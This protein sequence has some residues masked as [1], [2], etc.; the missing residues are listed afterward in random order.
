MAMIQQS[1]PVNQLGRI[2]G[3]TMSLL[4]LPGPLGLIFAGPI[5]DSIGIEKLFIIAGVGTFF[6]AIV[7]WFIKPARIYDQQLQQRLEKN[8]E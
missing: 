7:N 2:V 3:F 5:A 8:N 1:Y 6:C 4:S